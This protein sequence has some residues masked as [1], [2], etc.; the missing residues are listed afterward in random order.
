MTTSLPIYLE[1]QLAQANLYTRN[2][3]NHQELRLYMKKFLIL[4]EVKT[5]LMLTFSLQKSLQS[6]ASL[7]LI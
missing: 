7:F 4:N 1:L 3:S 6:F 2:I 5:S